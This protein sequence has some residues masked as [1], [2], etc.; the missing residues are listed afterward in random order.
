MASKDHRTRKHTN[1]LCI[2]H[3]SQGCWIH[4]GAREALYCTE[5]SVI[6]QATV[7]NHNLYV[8]SATIFQAMHF[9]LGVTL[10]FTSTTDINAPLTRNQANT[11]VLRRDI[12]NGPRYYR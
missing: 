4:R 5:I 8:S 9:G 1:I 2:R 12:C 11:T 10:T 7:N 3:M 6:D